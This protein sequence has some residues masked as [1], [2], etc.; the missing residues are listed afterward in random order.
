MIYQKPKTN[1]YKQLQNA[2]YLLSIYIKKIEIF[3]KLSKKIMGF[4]VEKL[5]GLYASLE[6][7]KKKQQQNK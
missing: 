3:Y 6:N 2:I 5:W 1:I 7:P 4:I